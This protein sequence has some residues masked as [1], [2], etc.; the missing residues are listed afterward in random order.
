MKDS[1]NNNRFMLNG[2]V[3][4]SIVLR[5]DTELFIA[6]NAHNLIWEKYRIEYDVLV[7]EIEE[8]KKLEGD[9]SEADRKWKELNVTAKQ[10]I[11]ELIINEITAYRKERVG[12]NIFDLE[13][14]IE[15]IEKEINEIRGLAEE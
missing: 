11:D 13:E 2:Q 9:L 8:I 7:N 14:R 6:Q 4:P 5:N 1:W 10:E 15:F 3:K 12:K